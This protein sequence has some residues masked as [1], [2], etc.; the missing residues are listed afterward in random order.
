[1]K[2]NNMEKEVEFENVQARTLSKVNSTKKS[3]KA[4]EN[5][6]TFSDVKTGHC[7]PETEHYKKEIGPGGHK[8]LV[9]RVFS[10][11]FAVV[12]LVV[13]GSGF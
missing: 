1:M 8:C 10:L 11:G 3:S 12:S 5:N 2:N 13:F 4:D 9:S 6:S 7:T